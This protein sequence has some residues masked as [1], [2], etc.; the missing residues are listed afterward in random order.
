ME[1]SQITRCR[2]RHSKTIRETIKKDLNINEL[3]KNMV[4]DCALWR[5]LIHVAESTYWDKISLDCCCFNSGNFETDMR[6]NII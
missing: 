3:D 2:R 6:R 1:G 4:F 5:C